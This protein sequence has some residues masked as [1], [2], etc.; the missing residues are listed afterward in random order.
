MLDVN[1]PYDGNLIRQVSFN[2]ADDVEAA[3]A[4]AYTLFENCSAWLPTHER[5]DILERTVRI[6][7]EQVEELT[8]IAAEEGAPAKLLK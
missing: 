5:V 4:Q 1:K 8:N 7:S 3:L 6:I 2:S